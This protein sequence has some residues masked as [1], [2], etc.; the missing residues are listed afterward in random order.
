MPS[1]SKMNQALETAVIGCI[2]DLDIRDFY[3]W[4]IE[5]VYHNHFIV[6]FQD[7]QNENNRNVVGVSWNGHTALLRIS[8]VEH[9]GISDTWADMIVENLAFQMNPDFFDSDSDDSDDASTVSQPSTPP[10]S[11]D[12][13][14]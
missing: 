7:R 13:R 8:V 2:D 11:R 6:T 3:S 10:P 5:E 9:P 12:R 14:A 4:H 1:P